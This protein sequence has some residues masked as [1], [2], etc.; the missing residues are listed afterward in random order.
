MKRFLFFLTLILLSRSF[1]IEILN[2]SSKTAPLGL[3]NCNML[4]NGELLIIQKFIEPHHIVFDIGANEGEYSKIIQDEFGKNTTI[5]AFEPLLQPFEILK[6]YA[7]IKSFNL[8]F[9]NQK[10]ECLIYYLK[11]FSPVS[12]LYNRE[13]FSSNP[14]LNNLTHLQTKVKLTTLDD[15][16]NKHKIEKLTL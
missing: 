4:K 1:C 12:S 15:F 9:S 11:E 5:F 8:G 7:S 13:C 16:C 14:H 3:N 6:Q 10:Q 2:Y